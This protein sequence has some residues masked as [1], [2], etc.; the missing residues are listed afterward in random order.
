MDKDAA[1]ALLD[2]SAGDLPV[3]VRQRVLAKAGGNPLALLELPIARTPRAEDAALLDDLPLTERLEHAFAARVNELRAVTRAMLL[4]AALNDQDSLAEMLQ[5]TAILTMAASLS[6][7]PLTERGVCFDSRVSSD[8]GV[9][10][11]TPSGSRPHQRALVRTPWSRSRETIP[12]A[13][14]ED[15]VAVASRL[16]S[17]A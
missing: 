12:P 8:A 3:A 1:E 10:G 4:V 2:S 17:A 6:A 9:S 14:C 13:G 11:E 15:V 7:M 5:A 16:E